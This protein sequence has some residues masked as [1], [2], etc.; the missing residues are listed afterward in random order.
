M[1]QRFA[2]PEEPLSYE[3][4][5]NG[6]SVA[7]FPR[8]PTAEPGRLPGGGYLGGNDHEFKGPE[9]NDTNPGPEGD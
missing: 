8:L 3:T 2:A 1:P 6:E 4:Q 7:Q 5:S 9:P